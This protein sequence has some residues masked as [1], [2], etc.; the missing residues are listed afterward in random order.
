MGKSRVTP[1]RQITIPRLELMAAMVA[2]NVQSHVTAALEVPLKRTVIWKDSMITLGYIR[3]TRA[4]YK[5]FV[6]N[7]LS[8]IHDL[9]SVDEWR[10]V[11]GKVNPADL[12][13]RG[14]SADYLKA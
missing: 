9:S 7:R 3:N 14:F 10:Y 2:S 4:R 11:A 6:A 13:Y 12:A 1:I 8:T 5:M